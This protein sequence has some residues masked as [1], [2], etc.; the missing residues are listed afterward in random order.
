MEHKQPV[1]NLFEIDHSVPP[2]VILLPKLAQSNQTI[3]KILL[4][5]TNR[6]WYAVPVLSYL[7]IGDLMLSL[8]DPQSTRLCD[9]MARREFLRA[10]GLGLLGGGAFLPGAVRAASSPSTAKAKRCILLFLLG[11]PPQHSTWDPKPNAPEEIR[12]AFRPI[13]TN[14][15]GTQICELLPQT[16][17]LIDHVAIL[18]AVTTG[19]H[20]HS[21]S[22]YAMLTGQ[23][24]QPLNRENANP[25]PPNDWP[26]MAAVV[27][28]LRGQRAGALPTSIRLP[29]HIFNTDQSVWPGQNS[30]F[31]G[32]AADPWLFRCEP[33]SADFRAPEIR[34]SDDVTM[35]RLNGRRNLLKQLDARLASIDRT[36]EFESFSEQMKQAFDLLGNQNSAQ[37]LNLG[38]EPD[39]IRERYGRN[40]FGQSVLLGRRL[41]E[42]GVSMVQ[43]N[44]FR[45]PDEPSVA[46][47]WDSH[48]DE[49][50]RLKNVLLP[51]LD[52]AYSALLRDLI[53]RNMLDDTL[54]VCMGE[55]GRT[56]KFNAAGGRDH[57]GHV[58]SL[59]LAGGGIQG[60]AV[61][62]VSD[63]HGAYPIGG[64]VRPE[65]LSATIFHC[66][67][68]S[69]ETEIRDL[70]NRP[71]PISRGQ[72][73]REILA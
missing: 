22:G 61:H 33:D 15:P 49:T 43:V 10:G 19:D 46:P 71:H 35:A 72:V 7:S 37:A 17:K 56:P 44:W 39:D 67:G 66:L 16:A 73:I 59:A 12:G 52:Q 38:S 29:M 54:V 31:L 26:T 34:L 68:F 62:G 47:C 45:G 65:D 14:V 57:W 5:A 50:A 9:G 58:F 55:F 18:R 70:L 21:S 20:A 60:G 69:P 48:A 41:L 32:A 11:G 2:T 42:A 1:R 24:H 25:G 64:V 53:D 28:H 36:G 6:R 30:G 51:P 27:H 63:N 8:I 13:S 23:S 3:G 40:Q 4:R